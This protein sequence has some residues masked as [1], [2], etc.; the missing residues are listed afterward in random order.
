[1]P[2]V[3]ADV[4][5]NAVAQELG[6]LRGGALGSDHDLEGDAPAANVAQVDHALMNLKRDPKYLTNMQT[7]FRKMVYLNFHHN[8]TNP[9]REPSSET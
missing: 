1:M 2:A 6:R 5:A 8:I 4:V 3:P 9:K 7:S